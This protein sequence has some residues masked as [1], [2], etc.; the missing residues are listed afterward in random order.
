[1]SK[2]DPP[3]LPSNQRQLQVAQAITEALADQIGQTIFEMWFE[4][5]D[6][7]V[8]DGQQ[9]QVFAPN[10]FSLSR[11]QSRFS[12]D[13]K[14][15]V[16]RIAGPETSIQFSTRT[17]ASAE[18]LFES[19]AVDSDDS[20]ETSASP[21]QGS[22]LPL[23][24]QE[25]GFI[26]EKDPQTYFH[27]H[28]P[29]EART[30]SPK[31]RPKNAKSARY[32]KSFWFGDENRLARAAV[33]QVIDYPGEFSPLLIY[34][35]TGS[36]KSH[37]LEAVVNEFRRR[38][39][40]KRC[41]YLSAEKFTT[42]FIGSLRGGSGLPMFRRRYRDLDILAI[43]DIQFFSSK[44]ATLS[45]FLQTVDHLARAG[46][47]VVV[48]ADRPP[49][50]LEGI[51]TDLAARL[52]GGLTCPLQYP[53]F[54]GRVSIIESICQQRNFTLP[55]EVRE[56]IAQHMTRDVRRIIGAINRLFA[57]S[58]SLQ[59]KVTMHLAQDVL[60]DLLAFSSIGASI[61]GIEQAVCDFC[62][63]KPNEIRSSSRRKRVC[64]ARMLAMYLA[65]RHTGAAF[66]EIGDHFGNRKHSTAI[67]ADKKVAGWV[68][69]SENISLPNASYPADEVIRRIESILRVG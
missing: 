33:E 63:V 11:L 14:E 36:G 38:L 49:I 40:R 68:E 7:I 4:G 56:L 2:Q 58:F 3:V 66:S 57:V 19:V 46:K 31:S 28:Q 64:T 9:V 45:E 20:V 51:G 29:S 35:S 44:R 54:E 41:V 50:E 18:S 53:S 23:E 1:M 47:Q 8:F 60:G 21:V 52:T 24:A 22:D 67:A 39:R 65:R 61:K 16:H 42:E 15:A 5:S 13:V 62:G 34:G 30:P 55:L 10:A 37:L 43:D 48:S 59:E 25:D 32:V 69:S 27:F 6:P 17:S 26:E 12:G